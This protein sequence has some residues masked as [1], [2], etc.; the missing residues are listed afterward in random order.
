MK[1]IRKTDFK[2]PIILK[3]EDWT[4]AEYQTLLKLFGCPADAERVKIT[5]TS[6]EW[7]TGR[8]C[9]ETSKKYKMVVTEEDERY[10]RGEVDL[11]YFV[12]H[13]E[14]GSPVETVYGDTW[15]ELRGDGHNEGLFY[16][17]Y[18]TSTGKKIGGGVIDPDL[19]AEDI[20]EWEKSS[21]MTIEDF[22]KS[23]IMEMIMN[24]VGL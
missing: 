1:H 5:C 13:P 4:E 9:S 23:V 21:T 2:E 6:V 8:E 19:P 22:Q 12:E 24:S 7:Y 15:E 17:L 10:E 3:P 18:E 16:Q 20:T 11:L 14:E